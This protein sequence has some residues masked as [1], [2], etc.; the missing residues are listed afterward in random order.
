MTL[1]VK[2]EGN[3][4]T[5]SAEMGQVN[6][7][8]QNG[9]TFYPEVSEDGTLSWTNDKDLPNPEPVNIRGKDGKDG[10]QGPKGDTGSQGPQGEPGK[11]GANGYTPVKGKDYWTE[12]DKSEIE[13]YIDQQ[14]GVIEN[15]SY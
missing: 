2:F 3:S 4:N 5:F 9:A 15:G 6:V 1:D 12:A 10:A 14:L 11:D 7:V 13:S 8:K